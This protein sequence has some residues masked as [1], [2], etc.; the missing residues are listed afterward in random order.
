[1]SEKPSW[2]KSPVPIACQLGP[3][4]GVT[5]R[6]RYL[7]VHFPD[8]DLAGAPILPQDVG[9]AVVV[10]IAR[11]DRFPDKPRIGAHRAAADDTVLVHLPDRGLAGARVL[12]Q[13]VGEAV[14]VE[15]AG[16]DGMKTRPGIGLT[17]PPP[18]RVFP[19]ISQIEAWPVLAFRHRMSDWP[20]SLKSPVPIAFQAGPGLG[21]TGPPPTR[22]LPSMSQIVAC[23]LVFCRRTWGRFPRRRWSWRRRSWRRRWIYPSSR[24]RS[25][26]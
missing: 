18:I 3:G 8:R 21:L 5:A 16:P 23:P 25:R 26:P 20:S 7:S 4:L 12:P 10:E 1:M 15:I 11:P 9:V 13:D 22:V 17:G 2:L 19:L 14:A 6:R 24:R